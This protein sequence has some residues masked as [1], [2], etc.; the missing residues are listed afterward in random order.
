[1]T[2]AEVLDSAYKASQTGDTEVG[3]MNPEAEAA[4]RKRMAAE[5][6]E[7]DKIRTN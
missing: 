4:T 5:K 1:M 2:A 7:N 3:R 6:W